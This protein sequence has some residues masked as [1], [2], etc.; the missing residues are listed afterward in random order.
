M[1]L[2]VGITGASGVI[3][4]IR[5]LEEL[6][7]RIETDLIISENAERIIRLETDLDVEHVKRKAT[8]VHENSDMTA[9]ISS[10]SRGYEGAVIIPCSMNTLARIANG[11]SSNLICR[12]AD[13]CLKENRKLVLV[14]RET[15]LSLVHIK[16][17]L[18]VKE[19]GA[20]LLPAC[21]AFYHQPKK[22]S[23][24]VDFIVSKVLDVFG[25]ENELIRRWK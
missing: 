7:G 22:I 20:I 10:G 23:D 11:I 12:V 18:S 1:R 3:Y 19:A 4:G 16:N 8:R 15:P 25:I 5:L 6:E 13:V 21:P 9:D 24:V 2:V 14:T 17:M